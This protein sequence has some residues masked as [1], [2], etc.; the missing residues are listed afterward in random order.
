MSFVFNGPFPEITSGNYIVKQKVVPNGGAELMQGFTFL[1][2]NLKQ[3]HIHE[4]FILD[5]M[6][7]Y[8]VVTHDI[9]LLNHKNRLP[10]QCK[11][12]I[13]HNAT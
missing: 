2:A 13:Y 4:S 9:A 7:F 10:L 3:V 1:P 6:E 8:F 5:H 11:F 12:I